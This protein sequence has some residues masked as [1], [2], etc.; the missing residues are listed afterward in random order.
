MRPRPYE[1][2]EEVMLGNGSTV[3]IADFGKGLLSTETLSLK[4]HSMLHVP[5]LTKNLIYVQRMCADNNVIIELSP[6][7]FCVKDVKSRTVFLIGGIEQGLYKFL[8]SYAIQN[9][10]FLFSYLHAH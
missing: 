2:S 4:L 1:G 7:S 6:S 9:G 10:I 5:M 8:I 3:S